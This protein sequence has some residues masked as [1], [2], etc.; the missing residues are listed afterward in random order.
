[1]NLTQS[2]KLNAVSAKNSFKLK[3]KEHPSKKS[4]QNA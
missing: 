2:F 4:A 3:K 1:L